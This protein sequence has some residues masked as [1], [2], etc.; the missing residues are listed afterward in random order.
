MPQLSRL[1]P[2]VAKTLCQPGASDGRAGGEGEWVRG[3]N[4]DDALPAKRSL[5]CFT[6]F[7]YK[8]S[9]PQIEA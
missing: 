7:L 4:D 2:L 5:F 1:Y 3:K 6:D 9:Y 8:F